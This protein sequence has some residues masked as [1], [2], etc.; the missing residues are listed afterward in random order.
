MYARLL[1]SICDPSVSVVT[2]SKKRAQQEL[3][4]ETKRA[5]D[6]AGQHLQYLVMEFCQC[7]LQGRMEPEV[8]KALNPGLYA[9]FDAMGQDVRRTINAAL[10]VKGRGIYK[11]LFEDYRRFGR[12]DG[13]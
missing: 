4:D 10:D 3:N 13:G 6:I 8:R 2:R 7:Q 5:R 1:T 11:M 12:W 9:I